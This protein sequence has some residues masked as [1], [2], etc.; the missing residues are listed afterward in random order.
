MED[1]PICSDENRTLYLSYWFER[2]S[3]HLLHLKPIP[4]DQWVLQKCLHHYDIDAD[5]LN[6][7]IEIKGAANTDQLKLFTDQLDLQL[8]EL[9]WPVDDGFV[10]VFGYRNR[11][12]SG[13]RQRLLKRGSG[14]SWETLSA[15]LAENTHVAYILDVRLL[16]L[17]RRQ[18]GTSRYTRN[19]FNIRHVVHLNRT[20]LKN[21][22]ENARKGLAELGMPPESIPRWLPPNAKRLLPRT[23][24]TNFDG[25]PV[26]FQLYLLTPN[27]FKNRFLRQLNATVKRH[28][29][30]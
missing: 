25:R 12:R 20:D 30:P 17:F 16:D 10:W 4:P 1:F 24:E 15:F 18:N 7:Y 28:K 23:I 6:A 8:G 22:A 2:L 3:R 11:E 5:A 9:G 19:I 14:T 29:T 21:L 13:I 26:S 27:G